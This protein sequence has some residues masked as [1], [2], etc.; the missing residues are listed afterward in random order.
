MLYSMTG[1]GRAEQSIGDKVFLIE[2][3]SLNGK[4]FDIRLNMPSLLK[5]YE[6]EIRNLLNEGLLRGSV[7]C[8]ISMKQNGAAKPVSINKEL[9][10]AYYQPVAELAKELDEP[11]DNILSSLLKLPDI[12]QQSGEA[13]PENEWSEFEKLL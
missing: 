13:L 7:E 4:Q 11:T 5:P 6:I 10:K 2:L 3:R 9:L 12:V 1:Y 8:I